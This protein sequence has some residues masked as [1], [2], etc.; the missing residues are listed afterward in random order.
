MSIAPDLCL[1][2]RLTIAITTKNRW[3]DLLET[4]HQLE[5]LGLQDLPMIVID[6]GSEVLAPPAV[7]SALQ[8]HRL[9]R[10]GES[11]G[12]VAQRNRLADLTS[13]EY[14]MS[15]DDDSAPISLDGLESVI[16]KMDADHLIAVVGLPIV[17]R[18]QVPEERHVGGWSETRAYVGCGHILRVQT[19]TE[20][21]GYAACL[22]YW[23][24]ERYY[25]LRLFARGY[26][27]M[28]SGAPVVLHRV[29]IAERPSWR[30]CYFRARNNLLIWCTS[31]PRILLPFWLIR[32]V[33]GVT[34]QTMREK[35]S[36]GATAS[37]FLDALRTFVRVN[38]DPV[39]RGQRLT[40]RQWVGWRKLP[41]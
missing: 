32:T 28:T 26:K 14:L 6:D 9:I 30:V 41:H 3:D 5:V 1:S 33:M 22:G 21:G 19:F 17:L 20:L 38:D 13:T 31:V 8:K 18:L 25:S 24:E 11:E 23:G 7:L 16:A 36:F 27:V 40:L 4:L 37:G 29:S 15:L 2:K 12:L 10:Y 39:F 35:G 34:F